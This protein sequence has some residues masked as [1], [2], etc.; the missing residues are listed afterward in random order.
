MRVAVSIVAFALE[1]DRRFVGITV[2]VL[3]IL[4]LGA[5]GVN[6][7]YTSVQYLTFSLLIF[8]GSI[9]AGVLGSLVGPGEAS[10]SFPC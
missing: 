6:A 8:V 1:H 5:L 2:L 7:A 4:L 3:A 10:S 9:V